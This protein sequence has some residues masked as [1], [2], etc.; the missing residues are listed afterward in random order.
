MKIKHRDKQLRIKNCRGLASIWGLTMHPMTALDGALVHHNN[1][2]TF[3]CRTL[4]LYF[5][6]DN[7][8][9]LEKRTSNHFLNPR[10]W[11][12]YRNKKAKYTLEVKKGMSDF[13]KGEKIRFL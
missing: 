3:L 2:G 4:D 9:V 12:G 6:S 11:T 8:V 1:I 5:L 7:F 13:R 10:S